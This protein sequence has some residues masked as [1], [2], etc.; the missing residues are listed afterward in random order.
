LLARQ[1]DQQSVAYFH[2]GRPLTRQNPRAKVAGT[3]SPL[4]SDPVGVTPPVANEVPVKPFQLR[5]RRL[6]P[7][8]SCPVFGSH[9]GSA[10]V[11]GSMRRASGPNTFR[12]VQHHRAR[13][14]GVLRPDADAK[15]A[16]EEV[17]VEHR[18]AWAY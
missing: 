12:G 4:V 6:S 13:V 10:M 17:H 15:R 8:R 18:Q 16:S 5:F 3:V 7:A 1:S 11:L 14:M 9:A 2:S